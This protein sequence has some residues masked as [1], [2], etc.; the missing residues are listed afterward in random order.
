M[1]D[2]NP[3][4]EQ[5]LALLNSVLETSPWI[6]EQLRKMQ[7]CGGDCVEKIGTV[8]AQIDMAKKIKAHWFP[9]AA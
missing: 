6:L 5:H 8:E 9:D 2:V 1:I 7:E 4:T 3:L